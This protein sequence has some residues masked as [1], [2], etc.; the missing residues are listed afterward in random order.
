MFASVG[1]LLLDPD[2][3]ATQGGPLLDPRRWT[4]RHRTAGLAALG[5]ALVAGLVEAAQHP[6]QSSAAEGLRAFLA[7]GFAAGVVLLALTL[8]GVTLPGFL[9]G[10]GFVGG[11]FLSWAY[12]DTPIVVWLLLLAEGALFLVWTFPWLRNLTGLPRLGAAWLGVAYWILGTIGAALV[13]HPTVAVQ[14]LV[15]AGLF[16]LAAM[17]IL[18]ATRKSGRDLSIG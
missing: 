18:V 12:M 11:A 6:P 5:V 16:T 1:K 17:A 9:V 10:L 2:T 13:W 7:A 14:R 15:Y 8:R 4:P 3:A